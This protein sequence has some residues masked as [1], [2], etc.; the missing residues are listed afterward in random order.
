MPEN[1][2]E[3]EVDYPDPGEVA[4]WRLL[5]QDDP[6]RRDDPPETCTEQ[7]EGDF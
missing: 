2:W 3:D 5:R 1:E 7:E 4:D 6:W